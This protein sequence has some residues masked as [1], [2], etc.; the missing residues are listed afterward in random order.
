MPYGEAFVEQRSNWGTNYKFNGK[1]L[2]E[3]TGYYYYGARYYNPDISIWLSVDP[4]SDERSWLSPYNYCQW[5][6]VRRVDPDGKIDY[7]INKNTGA[8]T[9]TSDNRYFKDNVGQIHTLPKDNSLDVSKMTEV[10]RITNSK[11]DSEYFT[12]GS[13][14]QSPKDLAQSESFFN[15]SEEANKFYGDRKSVV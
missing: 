8:I 7:E 5:N 9:K 10:D 1:E 2:D 4:L 13:I 15:S 11:G 14:R 6:P 3:E 12:A